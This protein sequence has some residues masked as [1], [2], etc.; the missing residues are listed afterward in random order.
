MESG[1]DVSVTVTPRIWVIVAVVLLVA[2]LV[3]AGVELSS[4]PPPVEGVAWIDFSRMSEPSAPMPAKPAAVSPAPSALMRAQAAASS[5]AGNGGKLTLYEFYAAWCD[6]CKAMESGALRN[7]Q[8]RELIQSRFYPVRVTDRLREDG[9]NSQ[10][11]IDLQKRYRI[12]AFPTLVIVDSRGEL[13]ASLVGCCSSLTTYR[14]LSRALHSRH[15]R[16]PSVALTF[17]HGVDVE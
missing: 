3:D 13:V 17:Q 8:V 9:K 6:P 14:F 5:P 1:K 15:H 4:T 12:F 16:R 7:A 10:D 11:V 2:R